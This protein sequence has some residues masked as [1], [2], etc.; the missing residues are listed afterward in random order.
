MVCTKLRDCY[1][2]DVKRIRTWTAEI[3]EELKQYQLNKMV[4]L[5]RDQIGFGTIKD[6][7]YLYDDSTRT[8][9]ILNRESSLQNNTVPSQLLYC[10]QLCVGLDSGIG[11]VRLKN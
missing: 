9:Q 1:L 4:V 5:G 3:N 6:G 10:D 2:Y 7:M 8:H 11:R